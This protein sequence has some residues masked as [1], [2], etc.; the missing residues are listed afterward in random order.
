MKLTT[1]LF[2]FVVTVSL[3][4]LPA[5][6]VGTDRA[7][8]S[9]VWVNA[10]TA[11]S[12]QVAYFRRTV[13]IPGPVDEA[14][15]HLFA[16]S[17][18]LLTV[19]G[20]T[21]N[22]GP[23]R[24]YPD[25]PTFDTYDLRPY[26][27][28]GE[29]VIGVKVLSNGAATFQLRRHRPGFIA[30]GA[31][32]GAKGVTVSL[33]TN[34]QQWTAHPAEGYL[35]PSPKSTF[36]LGPMEL[37]DGRREAGYRHWATD[38]VSPPDWPHP[39]IIP[40]TAWGSLTPRTIPQL[41]QT[42]YLPWRLTGT[43]RFD[44]SQ[45]LLTGQVVR[46][47]QSWREYRESET[48]AGYTY[49]YTPTARVINIL[50]SRGRY[51]LEGEPV[52]TARVARGDQL[53]Q[54]SLTLPLRSGWNR[55]DAEYSTAFGTAA[56]QFLFPDS[57]DIE[58]SPRQSR[59]DSLF[60]ATRP[61]GGSY[62]TDEYRYH[63]VDN[64]SGNPALIMAWQPMLKQRE[65]DSS[66]P[67]P[68][69]IPALENSAL[70]VDFRHKRLGR[71]VLEYDAPAGTVF[72]IGFAE[73]TLRDGWPYLMKR[74][75]LYMAVRHVAA[76]GRGRFETIRPYGLRQLELHVSGHDSTVTV[77]KVGVVN[78]VYPFRDMGSFACSDPLLNDIWEL[79]WRSLRV[80][81]EDS[82]TDTP[83]RERGLYAGDMLPQM[84]ITLTN[85][86][87]LRLVR[88]SLELFQDMYADLFQADRTAHPDEIDLLEDYPLLTLE[89]LRWYYHRTADTAFVAKLYPRY[90]FLLRNILARR[91]DRGLVHNQRVF[92][93]WTQLEKRDVIN[94]AYQA[95][96][97]R[98]LRHMAEFARLLEKPSDAETYEHDAA[99]MGRAIQHHLWITDR[100]V[101]SDGIKAGVRLNHS[102]PIS[103]TWPYLAGIVPPDSVEHVLRNIA[104][105]LTDIGAVPRQ[106]LVTPYGSF[107]VLSALLEGGHT[108]AV[109]NFIR[110]HWGPM[111]YR[112]NDT[113]W[114][115]FD[116]VALGT[117][118]HAW[119][120]SPTYF[121][122]AYALGVKLGWPEPTPR[123]TILIEPQSATL[124]WAEGTVPHPAGP[125]YVRWVLRG[126]TLVVEARGP[127]GIPLVV[128]PR[129]RLAEAAL[130]V[131]GR[132]QES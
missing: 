29:N 19:N 66:L 74:Q 84:A 113:A 65:Y 63:S 2:L 36:A 102:Y 6:G 91:D 23:A 129:G 123:D 42:E 50:A 46:P 75:G 35:H 78:Q 40:D 7:D 83:F 132:R 92:I 58:F 43:A 131:N 12:F 11:E 26:L 52:A 70:A 60:F 3:R 95:I 15:L 69:C 51:R 24:F 87:D 106:K 5:Q 45:T 34:G 81:A 97:L 53:E 38:T 103:S 85:D 108:R 54:Q 116:D 79:G 96:L 31:V 122:S 76:G 121:L 33:A 99:E 73:D 114:E 82:Y 37:H 16:D 112:R 8:A 125:V 27:R 56:V 41:T 20:V 13:P 49:V 72:N 61:P 119:S 4:E 77:S 117:L 62:D 44:S 47:E 28:P 86:T 127:E 1:L 21:V 109:E 59:A 93:E 48:I 55:L 126:P 101:F 88:R 57:L 94:T 22:F 64:T 9:F 17:R 120:G 111:I 68:W 80:C 90:D 110:A 89:A 67:D 14:T 115:N 18:Y 39:V 130:W 124:S 98:T 105:Q 32:R 10:D 71:I 104:Q 30:W 128:R 25:H 107:F 100:G 118:S